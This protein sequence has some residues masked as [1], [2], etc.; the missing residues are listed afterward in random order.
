MSKFSWLVVSL[1]FVCLPSLFAQEKKAE[2]SREEA[3]SFAIDWL[4]GRQEKYEPDPPLRRLRDDQVPKWQAGEKKRLEKIFKQNRGKAGEWPYE[5]VY[6]IRPDGR[7]PP[8]Y[9]VGG[10]AIVC[11]FLLEAPGFSQDKKRQEAVR[12]SIDFMSNELKTN[13]KLDGGPQ[14][15][16][17]VRGWGHTYALDFF[18]RA[19]Q[20][21]IVKSPKRAKK[22]RLMIKE[23]LRRLETNEAKGGGWNY[24]GGRSSSFMTAPTL[25]ALYRAKATGFKVKKGLVNRAI[26]ALQTGRVKNG[27][28]AYSGKGRKNTSMGAS[29]A[30]SHVAE[31]ALLLSGK[32][33]PKK[34]MVAV[35]GFFEYWGYLL[36]RK[37]QQGTHIPPFNMAPYYFYY[38]HRYAALAIEYLPEDDRAPMRA[39]L[40]KL[41]WKTRSEGGQ[42]NDR[43]F[44]RTSSFCTAEVGLAFLAPH[45]PR[46]D[47]WGK[48]KKI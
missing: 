46:L 47:T 35:D 6:R 43:I 31:L 39:K 8:G 41:L 9:R 19:H 22:L 29:A 7:I 33:T 26:K 10:S 20:T 12:R 45:L 27:A 11:T 14:R 48:K 13:E 4:L 16:Y 1:V 2:Q 23:L 40:E 25:L 24:T 44:P 32:S 28:F 42:W 15:G 21:K 17:D 37:S 18:L 34:M 36:K 3:V 5:G 38:G 30:R